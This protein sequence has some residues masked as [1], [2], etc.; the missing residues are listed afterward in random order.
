MRHLVLGQGLQHVVHVDSAGT[1]AYHSGESPDRR[2]AAAALKRGVELVGRARQFRPDDWQQFDYV[3]AM[4]QANYDELAERAPHAHREK[5]SLLLQ[6]DPASETG[7]SVPDPYYGGN[8][9]F[10][11][12]LDL[13]FA[14]CQGLLQHIRE[15][16]GL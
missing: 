1:A 7:A 16:H 8:Q 2:S 5:L 3:V 9:G 10:E 6:F 11:R 15:R 14:G 13:C 4:D 12:V